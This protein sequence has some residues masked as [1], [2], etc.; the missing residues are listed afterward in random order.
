MNATNAGTEEITQYLGAV[1]EALADLPPA[2][3]EELLEDLPDHL[4]EVSAESG[5]P[6]TERLGPPE[7]YAAELRAAAGVGP[8]AGRTPVT[9]AAAARRLDTVLSAVDTRLGPLVG[10][11]R[12]RDFLLLLRPAWWVLRGYLLA[13]VLG[14]FL[15]PSSP[16]LL[17]RVRGQEL[18]GLVLVF[19]CALGSIWVGQRSAGLSQVARRLVVGAGL[20][21]VLFSLPVLAHVDSYAH[22]GAAGVGG[23]GPDDP[24][25]GVSDVFPYGPDGRP[26]RGVTL[27]DQNGNPIQIGDAGRCQTSGPD[28]ALTYAYPL[29][30]VGYPLVT[31]SPDLTPSP[32]P[33]VTAAP[34]PVPSASRP[35]SPAPS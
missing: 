2:E 23:G 13:L 7:R 4:A 16:G 31:V 3:R 21:V 30:G 15:D 6:L 18:A 33:S 10:Q 9:L 28:A 8:G 26:L 27:Y 12:L 14:A 11:P 29:C 17:P 22:S 32:A 25:G 19:A 24:Y 35:P 20:L 5:Q 1:R 34:S